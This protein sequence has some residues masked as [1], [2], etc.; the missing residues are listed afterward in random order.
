MSRGTFPIQRGTGL[1]LEQTMHG[2]ALSLPAAPGV[3]HPWLTRLLW[4]ARAKQWVATILPGFVNEATPIYRAT[5]AEQQ[6]L[7]PTW[8]TNP[9]SGQPYFSAD[10]FHKETVDDGAKQVDVPLYLTP[11]LPL[12][13][14]NIGFDGAPEYPVPEYF[15]RLGVRAAAALPTA[16]E[17]AAGAELPDTAKPAG[18]RLLRACDFLLHQPR[19]ALTSTVS[20]EA[21]PA[22]GISN[23][24]Q[25]L[26]VRSET[27]GDVLRI[28]A[29]VAGAR[30]A[31]TI[32]PLAMDYTEQTFDEILISTVYLL[33]PVD[34]PL[35]SVPD[36]TWQPFVRHSQFW[37]LNYAQPG[38]QPLAEEPIGT[39]FPPLGAGAAQIVINYLTAS[40][41]DAARQSLNILRGHSMAG[42]F[43]TAT[44]GGHGAIEAAAPSN[45]DAITGLNKSEVLQKRAA[46]AALERRAQRLDPPFPYLTEPFDYAVLSRAA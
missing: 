32:D 14:R 41:N 46:A 21:G 15:Q 29:G 7:D 6:T 10:V 24:L 37:N 25:T 17:A 30:T 43:W 38:F 31:Q 36:L 4:N 8:G 16:E 19:S 28:F 23:V 40:L 12:A 34:A 9:L 1:T 2:A 3:T 35:G 11:L 44:G 13:L 5:V 42:R 39:F 33:S 22:T 26:S 27:P 20:L 45:V 18:L